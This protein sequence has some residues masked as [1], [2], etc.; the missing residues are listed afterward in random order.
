MWYASLMGAS[1]KRLRLAVKDSRSVAQALIK[2]GLVPAGG[3]YALFHARVKKYGI[4]TSHFSGKAWSKGLH[5][6]QR[7]GRTLEQLLQENTDCGSNGLKHRLLRAKL[8]KRRCA[9]CGLKRWL[10][11]PIVL[12]LDHINGDR[13]DNRLENL[14]LLCPNCHSQTDTFRGRN[15]GAYPNRQR[16]S[17]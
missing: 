6:P 7:S 5:T 4:D 2:M 15:T 1:V 13:R 9:I 14:R 3:N 10:D 8:L 12:E 17:A 16:E 11:K